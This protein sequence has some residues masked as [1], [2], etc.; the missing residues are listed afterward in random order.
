MK[1]GASA[2]DAIYICNATT[3]VGMRLGVLEDVER[4][5]GETIGLRYFDGQ[6]SATISASDMS[7]DALD[8]LV[9]RAG[10]MAKAAP[11]DQ[12]AGLAD[13]ELL[14][15]GPSPDLALDDSGDPDPQILRDRALEAEDA[16]RAVDGVTNSEGGGASAA[17]AAV[18]LSTSHGFDGCYSGS[19]YSL[20]ASV[21][22]GG[23]SDMQRDY[24]SHS[25]RHFAELED[26]ADI[27]RHAGERAVA[28]MN[29]VSV[30]SGAMPVVFDPRVGGTLVG[31]LLGAISGQA[32]ARKTSFLLDAMGEQVFDSG[33]TLHDNPHLVQGLRS[34]AFDGEG[35]P[36]Q[37]RKLIDAG[38]L[39]TWLLNAA[40][41]RQ[42]K[43]APTGHATRGTAGSP[44]TGASNL[45][46]APGKTSPAELMADV[47]QG[48]YVTELIGMGVNGVT[49]DYS[50]GAGGFL[51]QDGEIG[52]AVSGITIAGNL[53]DMFAAMIPASDLDMR[54][55]VNVPTLRVDGMTVAG[56]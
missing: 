12:Y 18:A 28:R 22:A 2:A 48:I 16:A 7:A 13:A 37:A 35:L 9:E 4:S 20:S 3:Q 11:E 5:E 33:V 38:R 1:S 34:K 8:T 21:L 49:G 15:T 42:L 55:S 26:A 41:A 29:P 45:H 40:T 19:M 43:L 25:I 24:A 23:G 14:M 30:K 53:K 31:H 46:I 36:T 52:P 54:R 44:G 6:R 51:I 10:H 39:T 50:R 56:D 47:K 17:R 27:G 32:I